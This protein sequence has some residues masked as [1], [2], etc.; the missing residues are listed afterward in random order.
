MQEAQQAA[1]T[2]STAQLLATEWYHDATFVMYANIPLRFATGVVGAGGR[3]EWRIRR[4][5]LRWVDATPQVGL[6]WVVRLLVDNCGVENECPVLNIH[7]SGSHEPVTDV[8]DASDIMNTLMY[9]S[10]GEDVSGEIHDSVLLIHFSA[11]RQYNPQQRISLH[12]RRRDGDQ[13]SWP[14]IL[15]TTPSVSEYVPA[16]RMD[17]LMQFMRDQTRR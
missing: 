16:R 11:P 5:G 8:D 15:M 3:P 14:E 17:S 6:P 9:H 13:R 7:R 4:V 12:V 10:R 2:L 1:Q